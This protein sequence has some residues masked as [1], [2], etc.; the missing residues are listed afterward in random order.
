[1]ERVAVYL[2]ILFA[3][4]FD[5]LIGSLFLLRRMEFYGSLVDGLEFLYA[6]P[7]D[8]GDTCY[9]FLLQQLF[10]F[11]LFSNKTLLLFA[12]F[13]VPSYE[14]LETLSPLNTILIISQSRKPS[15]SIVIH[16]YPTSL[17]NIPPT[18]PH[19][20]P[21]LPIIQLILIIIIMRF[22]LI[23]SIKNL[24]HELLCSF[25][26]FFNKGRILILKIILLVEI[27]IIIPISLEFEDVGLVFR[28]ICFLDHA[29]FILLFNILIKYV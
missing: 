11:Y 28:F 13:I 3:F 17:L 7:Q 8:L 26:Q 6:S 1:M 18:L 23:L 2:F 20:L 10:L 25:L 22:P 27:I 12:P 5:S 29:C 19:K 15:R 16:S 9:L 14:I 24:I 21:L 4:L